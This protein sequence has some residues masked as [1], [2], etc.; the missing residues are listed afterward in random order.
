[1]EATGKQIYAEY[2]DLPTTGYY[3]SMN[4]STTKTK[5]PS[6]LSSLQNELN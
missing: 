6:E 4:L 2:K 5:P 3:N 1:M